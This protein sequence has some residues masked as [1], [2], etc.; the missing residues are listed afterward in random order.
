MSIPPLETFPTFFPSKRPTV[1]TAGPARRPLWNQR[2]PPRKWTRTTLKRKELQGSP[3]TGSQRQVFV[4]TETT[5]SRSAPHAL[6]FVCIFVSKCVYSLGHKV[7]TGT[8]HWDE[9]ALKTSHHLQVQT[10]VQDQP[11]PHCP[12]PHGVHLVFQ[13]LVI[14]G[15]NPSDMTNRH[16]CRGRH[17]L[18]KTEKEHF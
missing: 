4:G 2:L 17:C 9:A 11:G 7:R 8:E 6:F 18:N 13:E 3:G 15:Q 12:L 16:S 14:G 1:H 10:F 5:S